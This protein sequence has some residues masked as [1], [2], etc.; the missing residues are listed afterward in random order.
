MGFYGNIKN[1]SRT[2]FNFDKVYPSRSEM[3]NQ[4]QNDGVYA[5]RYVLVEYDQMVHMDAFPIGYLKDGIL[6]ASIPTTATEQAL[7]YRL[8]TNPDQIPGT[9]D[10]KMGVFV[11]PGTIIHVPKEYNFDGDWDKVEEKVEDP[12][13]GKVTNQMVA[14]E[15]S[16]LY[17]IRPVE[18][19]ATDVKTYLLNP[20]DLTLVEN[21]NEQG[22][23]VLIPSLNHVS[24]TKLNPLTSD[25]AGVVHGVEYQKAYDN[26]V[27]NF[28]IDRNRY[29]VSRGYDSTVWQKVY[30][31]TSSKYVMVAEL[32]SVVPTFDVTADA[33]TMTP[34]LPHFDADSTN[35]YYRLHMQPAWGFRVKA[36]DPDMKTPGLT[37]EGFVM[38]GDYTQGR[39]DKREYPSDQNTTWKNVTYNSVTG[40]SSE[41]VFI[42]N[43]GNGNTAWV[44]A[45]DVRENADQIGAAIYFNKAG[46][47]PKKVVYSH[48]KEYRDWGDTNYFVSDEI[49]LTPTGRSGHYYNTHNGV[50]PLSMV[51]DTQELS[52]MLPSIGDSMAEIWDLIYGGRNLD[53]EAKERKLDTSW[54][55]A[56]AVSNKDGVRMINAIGPGRYTYDKKAAGTVAGVLNSVQDLMGM[57]ITDEVPDQAANAN[58][59]YIYYDK[60]RGKYLYKHQTFEFT[61]QSF[62]NNRIPGDYTDFAPVEDAMKEWDKAW[63]Y[64]DTATN[65]M[66]EFILEDTFYPTRRYVRKEYVDL[67]MKPIHLSAEYKPDGSFFYKQRDQ[68]PSVNGVPGA[69]YNYFIASFTEHDPLIQYYELTPSTEQ[70]KDNEA[71]YIPNTYYYITYYPVALTN[72]TYEPNVYY[73]KLETA[74]S[75]EYHLA[76]G[77]TMEENKTLVNGEQADVTQYF[78][79]TYTLDT[80]LSKA[81]DR[82]YYR[83][84]ANS[85]QNSNAYYKQNMKAID[86]GELTYDQYSPQNFYYIVPTK[87]D[88]PSGAEFELIGTIYYVRDD[89]TYSDEDTFAASGRHY[90]MIEI[91]YELVQGEDVIEITDENAVLVQNMRDMNEFKSLDPNGNGRG[92]YYI[93]I[94]SEG[95]KRYIEVNYNNFTKAYNAIEQKYEFVIMD[96]TLI[97]EPYH[98]HG[99]YYKVE[100]LATGK[101]GSYLVDDRETITPGRQYYDFEPADGVDYTGQIIKGYFVPGKFYKEVPKGSGNFIEVESPEDMPEDE[102]VYDSSKTLYVFSDANNIYDKGAIWPMEVKQI[103]EGVVLATREEVWELAEFEGFGDK[104]N[105]LHGLLL[106]LHKYLN[107]KDT[108]TRDLKTA[109]GS[110]NTF[111][112]LLDRFSTL[113]PAQF[114]IVD[115]YGRMHSAPHSTSQPIIY[116]NG[117]TSLETRENALLTLTID[118][119][120][121]K[122]SWK[123]IHS[124]ANTTPD[125]TSE[126]N[127]N[128]PN[129]VNVIDFFTP[130]LDNAGHVVGKNTRTVTLPYGFKKVTPMNSG[131]VNVDVDENQ[132]QIVATV[133]QDN[134]NIASQNKWLKLASE[135]KTIKIAHTLVSA[136]FGE[137]KDNKQDNTPKF[138]DTFNIPVITVDNAGHVTAF[139]TETVRMPGLTFT[140][141]A[142]ATNDVVLNMSYSYDEETDTGIFT[143]ER[144]HVDLLKIQDYNITGVTSAKLTKDDTIH[145]AFAKL[146]AQINAMDLAKVGGGTG[147][148][149]TDITVVDGIVTA[150]KATLPSVTDTAKDGEFVSAVNQTHGEITIS[151]V[152]ITPSVNITAGTSDN[153]PAIGITIN[154]KASTAQALTI[155][156]TNVYGV[157]KLTADYIA[158]GTSLAATGS[159]IKKA[160]ETLKATG[161]QSIGAG[162]TIKSWKEEN[163]IISLETQIIAITNDNV[164]DAT[165]S[166]GKIDGLQAALDSK[167]PNIPENTYDSYGS[168]NK[169]KEDL[170]GTP[171]DTK[172]T[173]TLNGLSTYIKAIEGSENDTEE[174]L[175]IHGLLAYIKLLEAKINEFHPPVVDPDAGGDDTT[176]GE[177][178]TG[179]GTDGTEPNPDD[180]GAS[181]TV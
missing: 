15:S 37:A 18:V 118:S 151:R 94:D 28:S 96:F 127:M 125:T 26:Y 164:A 5:G 176:G 109:R 49:A 79:R 121:E 65:S 16:I 47:D 141:D 97:G 62:P 158:D 175:T 3:D 39:T 54:Y 129:E 173:L 128:S 105:T 116:S 126:F 124:D 17:V 102:L 107:E 111:N 114:T 161:N 34:V 85:G 78:K 144:G 180:S 38:A 45:A 67:A 178:N 146:Q 2:Q 159:S 7:P 177:D 139:N 6:W 80:S 130:I 36:S 21:V 98:P 4:C 157:T 115:D 137:Q 29:G 44:P 119:N 76:R 70:I 41:I 87:D 75:V 117:A 12:E 69:S 42:T 120:Y 88:V 167:Q 160:I 58:D 31:G 113:A 150:N 156:S 110:V 122:P 106:R 22:E 66:W 90:Y 140:N 181:G 9:S 174:S 163:G 93:Y 71:I 60:E 46:F 136:D 61:Q 104:I 170:T 11:A 53:P 99:F 74:G 8:Q 152:A 59:D 135:G 166:I 147:E 19:E 13:T 153:A 1:T 101:A 83:V 48:D 92:I 171:E 134:F 27:A 10:P 148:Y 149:L 100:D 95:A 81:E 132:T 91:E 33:P 86:M 179:G 165:L 56:K 72:V 35:I 82:V 143:E 89:A 108:F 57:I 155:A 138:G 52:I 20:E 68:Y 112:D 84:L 30:N 154:T 23:L 73:Y 32:N 24:F 40:E 172:E 133:T 168:A 25:Y 77:A 14:K 145:G 169:V 103:P 131:A 64:V 162:Y 63:M 142:G 51:P 43:D 55:N 123:L 50:E